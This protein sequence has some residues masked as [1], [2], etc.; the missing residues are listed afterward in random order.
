M[1][2]LATAAAL[3]CGASASA[4]SSAADSNSTSSASTRVSLPS[5]FTPPRVFK[6]TNLLRNINLEKGYVR[7]QTNVVIENTSN[8]P[9]TEYYLP[10]ATDIVGKVG[11]LEAW[12]KNDAQKNRFKIELTEHL[13]SR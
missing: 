3:L 7:D 4:V 5:D 8:K 2:F 13:P 11:G 1:R 6:N 12:D 10:F 9:Q